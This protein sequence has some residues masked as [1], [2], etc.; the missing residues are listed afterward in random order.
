MPS[1]P[2]SRSASIGT[3]MSCSTSSAERPRASV[4]ISTYGGVNSRKDVYR[5]PTKLADASGHRQRGGGQ[6]QEPEP[7]LEAMIQRV[8]GRPPADLG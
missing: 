4:W 7:R 3:V 2:F 1:T 8:T 5:R 6:D